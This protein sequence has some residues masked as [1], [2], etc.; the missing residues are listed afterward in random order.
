M[1][2]QVLWGVLVREVHSLLQSRDRNDEL[3]LDRLVGDFDPWKRSSLDVDLVLDFL[4][5]RLGKVDRDEND[6]RV[7]SVL[8]LREQIRSYE[9]WVGRLVRDD[10]GL[11]CGCGCAADPSEGRGD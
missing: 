4:E 10:L 8:S 2:D 5:E 3:L 1:Q 11:V 6:L 9:D 7:R